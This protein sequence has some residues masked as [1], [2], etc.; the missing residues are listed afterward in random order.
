MNSFLHI[1]HLYFVVYQ[2]SLNQK[3][4]NA[5][6]MTPLQRVLA[7]VQMNREGVEVLEM[8]VMVQ[9]LVD[10]L[11]PLLFPP[12]SNGRHPGVDA[13]Y[14]FEHIFTSASTSELSTTT[15]W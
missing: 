1:I 5:S 15:L 12:G 3:S 4:S 6:P 2:V 11:W 13:S 7:G 8:T 14:H 9:E 10:L